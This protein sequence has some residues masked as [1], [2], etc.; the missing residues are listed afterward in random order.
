MA[1]AV[2]DTCA[3]LPGLVIC[4]TAAGVGV[5]V[6]VRAT[7]AV[8]VGV[9]TAVGDP[10]APAVESQSGYLIRVAVAVAVLVA[11]AV[12]VAV[13]V[14]PPLATVTVIDAVPSTVALE[15]YAVA[16]I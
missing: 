8:A 11:I 14:A 4:T 5:A 15:E 2:P 7:V 6:G 12:A 10:M 13:G 3:P 1:T 9:R 16:E